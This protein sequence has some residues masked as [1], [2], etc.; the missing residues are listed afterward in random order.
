MNLD[1]Y[2]LDFREQLARLDRGIAAWQ[3]AGLPVKIE[4]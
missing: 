3:S 1:F 4:K 2:A